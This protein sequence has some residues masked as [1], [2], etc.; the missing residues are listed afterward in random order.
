M[1][2]RRVSSVKTTLYVFDY[3]RQNDAEHSVCC[4]CRASTLEAAWQ[5]VVVPYV[6]SCASDFVIIGRSTIKRIG[7]TIM[8][9]SVC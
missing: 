1:P 4:L 3:V 8:Y 5:D 6:K 7:A 9:M 2:A